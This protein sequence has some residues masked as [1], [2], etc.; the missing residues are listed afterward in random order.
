MKLN[1]KHAIAVFPEFHRVASFMVYALHPTTFYQSC[2]S[3]CLLVCFLLVWSGMILFVW[4]W[5]GCVADRFGSSSLTFLASSPLTFLRAPKLVSMI[6]AMLSNGF[7]V[8]WMNFIGTW[9]TLLISSRMLILAELSDKISD[10][11]PP[12]LSPITL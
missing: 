8:T 2:V 10:V 1:S 3:C 5:L 11:L 7:L 6:V 9:T 4:L 12:F